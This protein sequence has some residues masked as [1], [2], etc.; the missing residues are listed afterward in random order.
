MNI[1]FG[2]TDQ[3]CSQLAWKHPNQKPILTSLEDRQDKGIQA[4]YKD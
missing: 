1:E 2:L 4:F 3:D